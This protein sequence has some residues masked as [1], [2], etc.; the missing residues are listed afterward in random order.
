[1]GF[2]DKIKGIVRNA[3]E[4]VNEQIAQK[5]EEERRRKEEEKRKQ[6]EANRFNPKDKSLEWF[7]SEDGIT[8]F[9]EHITV[10]NYFFEET[11]KKEHEA[12]YAEYSFEAFASVFHKDAKL[13]VSYFKSLADSMDVQALQY[14]GPTNM[15]V[16]V[17]CVQ[18]K[19]FYIDDDGEPQ[20]IVYALTPEE[21]V[22]AEKNPALNFVANFDCFELK[23]DAQGSWSDKYDLWSNVLIWLGVYSGTD[24]DI[25]TLNPWVF[26]KELY[27]NEMGTIRKAKG[28]YKKCI[29]FTASEKYKEIFTEKYNECE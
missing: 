15:L 10:Q 21:I 22:S 18:A 5:Q 9:R 2:F 28:F 19:P 3:K 29:E 6:E 13:P 8:A 23:D 27:F 4:Q 17:L 26:S 16:D 1:M 14:V 20:P 25:L 12:K 11:V 24:K 7:G